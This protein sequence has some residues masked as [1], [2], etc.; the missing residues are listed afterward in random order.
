MNK[1]ALT[2][3]MRHIGIPHT[4]IPQLLM[5]LAHSHSEKSHQTMNRDLTFY[6]DAFTWKHW[7]LHKS[8][9]LIAS[10]AARRCIFIRPSFNKWMNKIPK[11]AKS[12]WFDSEWNMEL[13]AN[14][15]DGSLATRRLWRW[16]VW[17]LTNASIYLQL[18]SCS[19]CVCAKCVDASN[20]RGRFLFRFGAQN[21]PFECESV[22]QSEIRSCNEHEQSNEN[23]I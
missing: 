20:A 18:V 16:M 8:T 15:I 2:P 6:S 10:A 23:C 14:G 17:Q 7:Y 19:V 9:C 3:S 5:H 21:I 4:G 11:Q 22:P 13:L 1:F 12:I